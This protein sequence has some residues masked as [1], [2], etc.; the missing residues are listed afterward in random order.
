MLDALEMV[1]VWLI[2]AVASGII[3]TLVAFFVALA[4]SIVSTCIKAVRESGGGR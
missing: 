2:Y 1:M 3:L 4:W